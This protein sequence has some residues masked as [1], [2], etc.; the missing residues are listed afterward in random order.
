[1]DE[2]KLQI[3][4]QN[5]VQQKLLPLFIRY[6]LDYSDLESALKW[7]PLVLLIGNYSSG[8]STFINELLGQDL[9]R[10]GQ[11]PTDDSFTIITSEGPDKEEGEIPGSVLVNDETLPFEFFK[12]H[13]E[14]FIAHF[15]LKRVSAPFLE[16][17]ALIDTP[18]M[19][20]AVTEKDR[21]YDYMTVVSD[22]AKLADL[23]VLM[24]DPHKAGTIKETYTAI[25]DTLPESSTEDRILFVMNRIDEC[26]NLSDLV[27]SYGTLCW[28][29]SQM[30][31]RKDIPYIFLTYAPAM[32]E[33]TTDLSSWSMERDQLKEKILTAP[34]FRINHIL[35]NIDQQVNELQMISEAMAVFSKQG[36]E[37]L[38]NAA[39]F[40]ITA[41]A[42]AF[43]SSGLIMNKLTGFPEQ[44]FLEAMISGSIDLSSF[45]IPVSG[46]ALISLLSGFWFVKWS[47]PRFARKWRESAANLVN[48]NTEYKR[49]LWTKVAVK[50]EALLDTATVKEL[51]GGHIRNL[52]KIRRFLQKDLQGFYNK[53]R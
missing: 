24:F 29:L 26:D 22:F 7:K 53:I 17:M 32:A 48:L 52:D 43:F 15:R 41:G 49:R 31:G 3:E 38:A 42:L 36:R 12:A 13:G 40:W 10:T 51:L 5:R 6:G 39:K 47:F 16:N 14:Q 27:R 30:T 28:N 34:Q 19:L 33:Q 9:Q 37:L 2:K 1:M 8:K 45:V 18:G 21:G 50:V 35:Q 20:D 44:T 25:R 11:A 46:V 4:L 23:V